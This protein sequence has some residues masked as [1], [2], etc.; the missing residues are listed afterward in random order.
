MLNVSNSIVLSFLR[1]ILPQFKHF[2]PSKFKKWSKKDCKTIRPSHFLHFIG[3]R[4]FLRCFCNTA[5][6]CFMFKAFLQ[7]S[8]TLLSLCFLNTESS[9]EILTLSTIGQKGLLLR[10]F[11]KIS[12]LNVVCGVFNLL[13]VVMQTLNN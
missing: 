13:I 1:I 11:V 8:L 3:L 12:L 10:S 6:N 9:S 5:L 2:Q 4:S 7:F